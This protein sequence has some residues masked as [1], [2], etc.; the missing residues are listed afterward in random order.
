MTTGK[1]CVAAFKKMTGFTLI[2][3][4]IVVTVIAILSA[5]AY[6]GYRNYVLKSARSEGKAILVTAA[7]REEAFFQNNKTYTTDTTTTG[8]NMSAMS[9]SGK[10]QLTITCNAAP[11]LCVSFTLTATPQGGQTEDAR[12]LILTLTS[13]GVKAAS[14]TDGTECW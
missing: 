6:P 7:A 2:E 4:M 13:A 1:P 3:L 11:P 12:C 14:G 8:L 10:Y 9:E 5:V